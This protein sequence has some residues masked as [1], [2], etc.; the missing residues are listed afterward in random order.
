MKN[1]EAYLSRFY[2]HFLPLKKAGGVLEEIYHQ[3]RDGKPVFGMIVRFSSQEEALKA[4]NVYPFEKD[5]GIYKVYTQ[6]IADSG[7]FLSIEFVGYQEKNLDPD[8]IRALVAAM[9]GEFVDNL[10]VA[11]RL[12][13]A[14]F[15]KVISFE[16][17]NVRMNELA[18]LLALGGRKFNF[19]YEEY[20]D[21]YVVD[22]EI[23]HDDSIPPV[24]VSYKE[25]LARIHRRDTIQTQNEI[26][27]KPIAPHKQKDP[28]I[29]RF[30]KSLFG[31]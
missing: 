12:P 13:K 23:E 14:Y 22:I 28:V 24:S 18:T 25:A 7:N 10:I 6:Y 4:D 8:Q 31:G 19:T 27:T 3:V 16:E 30:F 5:V 1:Y 11:S 2:K 29:F 9:G 21:H 20:M 15:G 17:V 26:E